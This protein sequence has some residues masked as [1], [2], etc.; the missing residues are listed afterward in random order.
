[1]GDLWDGN[2]GEAVE[3]EKE[4]YRK[5]ILQESRFIDFEFLLK[6]ENLD[7]VAEIIL[8][9]TYGEMD[10][11]KKD[12][13]DRFLDFIYFKTQTGHIDIPHMVYPLKR[14][15][16]KDLEKKVVALINEHL[17]PEIVLHVLKFFSRNIHDPDSNLCLAN[18]IV[19][20][21]IITSVYETYRLFKKDIF[22]PHPDKRT[23]NVKRV[24]QFSPR[25]DNKLS[26]PLDQAAIYKYIL[27]FFAN[28][29]DMSHLFTAEDLMLSVPEE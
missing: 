3:S 12:I 29:K 13:I 9:G 23:L 25:S 20:D 22:N 6:S 15:M 16:D 26:S 1:M 17:Y 2:A 11:M 14:M 5:I 7:V 8:E 27:E 4:L 24:Q 19:S 21:E 18:L 28:R 10:F